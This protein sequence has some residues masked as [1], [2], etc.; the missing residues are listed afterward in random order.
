MAMDPGSAEYEA[1][2]A[3]LPTSTQQLLRAQREAA[4][5]PFPAGQCPPPP[6]II[7]QPFA[8]ILS[9]NQGEWNE[10]KF[11]LDGSTDWG[12]TIEARLKNAPLVYAG[13]AVVLA[14]ALRQ[15]MK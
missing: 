5:A 6:K 13:G 15:V 3:H 9:K 1:S 14:L 8:L 11:N 12:G 4:C 2:I 7:G 10:T